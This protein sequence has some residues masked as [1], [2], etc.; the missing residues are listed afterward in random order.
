MLMFRKLR[1]PLDLLPTQ[2][3]HQVLSQ[4]KTIKPCGINKEMPTGDTGKD[5]GSLTQS[6][7]T[8]KKMLPPTRAIFFSNSRVKSTLRK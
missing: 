2:F 7:S 6:L 1:P 8:C 5:Q 3:I 4:A